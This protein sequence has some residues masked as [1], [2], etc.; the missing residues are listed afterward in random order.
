[1][2]LVYCGE[3]IMSISFVHICFILI[4]QLKFAFVRPISDEPEMKVY[5][6]QM[7]S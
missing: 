6:E 5:H 1:M 2:I 7:S 3:Y 4:G